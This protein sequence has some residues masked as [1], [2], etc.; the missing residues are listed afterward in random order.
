MLFTMSRIPKQNCQ[1]TVLFL[2]LCFINHSV[3]QIQLHCAT[4]PKDAYFSWKV[5]GLKAVS[6]HVV[7]DKSLPLSQHYSYFQSGDKI[8]CY[9][10]IT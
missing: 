4:S 9:E 8:L 10:V 6:C 2:H 3:E 5:H 1:I 7:V